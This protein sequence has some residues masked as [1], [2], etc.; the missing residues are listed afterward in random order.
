MEKDDDDADDAP[1]SLD[2]YAMRHVL[3]RRVG[4]LAMWSACV[5]WN[6]L[7]HSCGKGFVREEHCT[8]NGERRDGLV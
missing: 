6:A 7:G 2:R 8:V 4:M 1:R 3:W 5:D